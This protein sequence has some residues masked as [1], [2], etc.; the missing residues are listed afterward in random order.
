[1]DLM[2]YIPITLATSERRTTKKINQRRYDMYHNMYHYICM[3]I[4][5]Y[6]IV[7]TYIR[8]VGSIVPYQLSIIDYDEIDQR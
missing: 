5:M 7:P 3:A 8:Y 4:C 2:R 1:M 6:G